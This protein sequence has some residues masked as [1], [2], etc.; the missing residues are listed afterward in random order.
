MFQRG[1]SISKPLLQKVEYSDS[2]Y[3]EKYSSTEQKN[4]AFLFITIYGHFYPLYNEEVEIVFPEIVQ[5]GIVRI[6]CF[7]VYENYDGPSEIARLNFSFTRTDGELIL[8]SE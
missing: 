6:Y 3:V 7:I 2:F 5:N 4:N 8:D 1:N